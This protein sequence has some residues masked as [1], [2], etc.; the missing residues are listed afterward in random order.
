VL[1]GALALLLAFPAA[2]AQADEVTTLVAS[3]DATLQQGTPAGNFGGGTTNQARSEAANN[4]RKL[5]QFSFAPIDPT[6]AV[7][8]STLRL[9]VDTAPPA[10][11]S[12]AVH[13]VTGATPWDENS[14]TWNTRDGA[15]AWGSPG[16]DFDATPADTQASGTT[17]G[18]TVSWTVL[19]DGT[20]SNI[21]QGWLDGSVVNNGLLVKDTVEDD[22]IHAVIRQV[23]TGTVAVNINGT[24]PVVLPTPLLNTARAFL[25]FGTRTNSNRPVGSVLRGRILDVNTL[26]FVRVTDEAVPTPM[27]VRWYVV[28]FLQGVN[29]QRGQTTQTGATV[30]QPIAAVG[31][32]AQAFVTF[33]KTPTNTDIAWGTNDPVIAALTATNNLQFR[34]NAGAPT[35]IIWWQVIEFLNPADINVQ[36][37]NIT[38]MTGGTLSVA[39]PIG[40]VNLARSFVLASYRNAGAGA[41]I[42]RRMLRAR[43]TAPNQITVDRGAAGAGD[44]MTEIHWQVVEL[45]DGSAVQGGTQNFPAGVAQQVIP[46]GTV[47]TTRSAAFAAVQAGAGQHMGQT[48]YVGDDLIGVGSFTMA[49]AANQLTVDRNSTVAASDVGWFVTQ[50]ASQPAS[51][52]SYSAREDVAANRPQ[53]DVSYLRNVTMNPPTLGISE[54]TLNWD[55]PPGS[56]GAN[57]DGVL[58]AKRTGLAA[59]TFVPAD[60]TA[61]VVGAQPVPG[62]FIAVN[63]GA[64]G[65]LSAT[66]ENGPDNVVLP[67]TTYTYRGYTHDSTVIAGAATPAPP[68]YAF[69]TNQTV[70]TA[71]G[72]GAL[73]NW[74][75]ATGAVAL[76]PPGLDPANKVVAGSNDGRVHSMST[77][78][79]ARNYQPGGA[80]GTTGGAIQARPPVIRAGENTADCDPGPGVLACD[81]VFVGA[82]DGRVYAFDTGTGVQVW[83]S[84]V[85]TSGLG[86]G[87][88][89]G[90]AVMVKAFSGPGFTYPNDLVMVG[91]RNTGGG[92]TGNNSVV[93]LDG[94]TGAVVWT[95]APGNLDIISSTPM[96]DMVNNTVW[97]SSRSN[98]GTQPSLWKL[99]VNTGALLES[100]SL[101]DID[102]S[103]TQSFGGPVV[104]VVTNA[105][106]LAAVRTDLA[107]CTFTT[108]PGTGAGLGFPIP[109]NV[110]TTTN[111]DD[112]FFST[113]TT[114]NKVNFTYGTT[115]S[116]SFLTPAPGWT[117]P[118]ITTPSTPIVDPS[119]YNLFIYV[120]AGDGRLYKIA[121]DDGAIVDSR[122]VNLAATVGDPSYD[123]FAL[124]FYVGDS[125]GRIYSFDL[126]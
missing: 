2:P 23:Q 12:Q 69:G 103:P 62:E 125:S 107:A 88:Q 10:S 63:T 11:R 83:Q 16:G 121:Q 60:G 67:G 41:D 94:N 106:D 90:A 82:G 79:G 98:G 48:P 92:S 80:L 118:A 87:I 33:S 95:F 124:R 34:V 14:V 59:P 72:G 117:N 112:L 47:D 114:V 6:A 61:Y 38:T 35:H 28:E 70:T 49:L 71:V 113:A 36:R 99:D 120:G 21:P 24:V 53:L 29:V 46:I 57:Y 119:N 109:I 40:P 96:L 111:S 4:Y 52:V 43:F 32:L 1:R 9:R 76:A 122:V 55:F 27:D 19:S 50:F 26:E 13:R 85:L 78:T 3:A 44:N 126:F 65:T 39:Q 68:H 81:I 75:Y 5:V 93:A 84:A 97:V 66:D 37:G 8:T 89:G 22:A 74:S 42:G 73:K 25:V 100:F 116:G 56:T 58:F 31:S 104:Y 102:G 123:G 18:A 51:A 101:G 64:F 7:K 17:S 110:G 86:S 77:A 105:G 108:N 30:N 54:V 115:C 20:A 15:T 91:T 45:N